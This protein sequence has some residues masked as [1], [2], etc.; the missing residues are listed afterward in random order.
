[1]DTEFRTGKWIFTPGARFEDIDMTRLDFSTDDPDRIQGPIQART[2]NLSE[3]IPGVGAL[4]E[5]S[6]DWRVFG[7]V[8]K[9]FN[10][11]APGSSASAE[12]SRNFELGT[13]FIGENLTVET[14][15][16]LNDYDNLV[17]TVTDSTGGNGEIGDQFDGGEAT[18][19]GIEFSTEFVMTEL[20]GGRID[21]PLG[22]QYTWTA[23]A[24]FNS[25][26][27]S[28]FD[29]WG[30]ID[31]GDELPYIPEHQLQV[32]AGIEGKSFGMNLAANYV[33]KMRSTAGQGEFIPAETVP[34]HVVWDVLARWRF[35][36]SLS[37]YIKVDNL[38]NEIYIASRRPSGVRPGLDR[39]AYIGLTFSL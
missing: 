4:Y 15:Y 14:I 2:N 35:T 33:G 22:L 9:G 26:F 10:P 32:S 20:A 13:R 7:G 1:V 25:A 34:S 39:T 38:F 31:I 21:V 36:E 16:F 27:A 18:V 5:I 37:T 8:N 24:E 17:G 19:Q 11:P 23:A 12:S 6:D 28:N 30:D 3:F 29:P